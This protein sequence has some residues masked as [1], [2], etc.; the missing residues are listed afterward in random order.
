MLYNYF[1]EEGIEPSGGESQK[2]AIARLLYKNSDIF[3]LDEPT[4][5]LDPISEYEV[6]KS[7]KL[8]SKEH[9][10]IFISHRLSSVS[11]CDKIAVLDGGKIAE[12]GNFEELMKLNGIF[13]DMYQAQ[14]QY[15]V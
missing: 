11:I 9:T 12:Y 15:Y 14:A 7:F 4:A 13:A 5:A 3:I 8:I 6:F 1:D 2:I 10:T